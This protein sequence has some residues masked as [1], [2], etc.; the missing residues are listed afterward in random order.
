MLQHVRQSLLDDSVCR[1]VDACGEQ[2]W[3]AFDA[4]LC[5]DPGGARLPDQTLHVREAWLRRESRILVVLAQSAEQPPHLDE[6]TASGVLD[7]GEGNTGEFRVDGERA[8]C[9]IS[10]DRDH[11]DAVCNLVVKLTRNAR[12]LFRD[13]RV[14]ALVPLVLEPRGQQPLAAQRQPGEPGNKEEGGTDNE[15]PHLAARLPP[16]RRGPAEQTPGETADGAAQ[17]VRVCRDGVGRDEDRVHCD[18]AVREAEHENLAAE[19]AEDDRRREQRRNPAPR[20]GH[21]QEER[22]DI[23]Q[24][25]RAAVDLP[26]RR[27]HGQLDRGENRSQER[28]R[29]W[30]LAW[31]RR[32]VALH[33][34]R[35]IRRAADRRRAAFAR[36]DD[37]NPCFGRRQRRTRFVA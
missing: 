35:H 3:L 5:L 30:R 15:I 19:R 28:V 7:R 13:G 9:G 4:Q 6:C 21:R 1:E 2:L 12:T 10:L 34:A 31:H 23:G 17:V 36:E 24:R 11:A 26:A 8:L 37:S 22:R 33:Q 20:Q 18:D 25:P 16:R 14:C 29:Q 27:D 32:T